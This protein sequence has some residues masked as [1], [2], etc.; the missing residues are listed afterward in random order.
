[1]W[2]AWRDSDQE[3]DDLLG[4]LTIRRADGRE[5]SLPEFPLAEVLSAS[6]TVRAEEIEMRGPGKGGASP[7][8]ST[9]SPSV[10]MITGWSRWWLLCR[11]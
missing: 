9:P 4:L 8:C 3:L 2:T 10:P 1:M 5:V 7:C 6:E 11:T